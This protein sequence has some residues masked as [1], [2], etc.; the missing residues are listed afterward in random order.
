MKYLVTGVT[1]QLGH[2]IVKE[3]ERRGLTCIAPTREDMP[4]D[5]DRQVES[6]I[7]AVAPD[8]VIHCAAYTAVD[9][10]ET[11][12]DKAWRVN[13]EATAN[14]ARICR[15][16]GAVLV[17]ISTDYVF[18]GDGDAPYS[19]ADPKGPKNVYGATKLAGEI[20]VRSSLDRYFIVRI[21][22]VFGTN[23]NNF[24]KTM[25][26]LAETNERINVVADQIGSPTYT[27]DAAPRIIDLAATD[28]YGTY[29]LTNEGTCSWA[30][31]ASEVFRKKNLPTLVSPITTAEYPTKAQ[32][33]LNS[34]LDKRNL[35]A[36]GISR[37]PSWQ[38]AL[39]RYLTELE[40]PE[41]PAE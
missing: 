30:E 18:P 21:S 40:A 33:P 22:W 7:N 25:L 41:K 1:G 12:A 36:A 31:L 11:E 6:Y 32:R 39:S 38:D 28:Y 5:D 9:K 23:G 27:A 13:A 8:I 35:L 3:L 26:R 16:I 37:M 15:R 14:I 20:A 17:Y 19:V 4:L 10:A 29:H 2:D 34:R 24:I